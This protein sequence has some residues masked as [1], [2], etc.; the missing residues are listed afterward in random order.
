SNMPDGTIVEV[1]VS[2]S[3]LGIR[4]IG[5]GAL[6]EP[7]AALCR[8]QATVASLAVDAAAL[9]SRELMLQA[10]LVDPMVN[11]MDQAK[12]LVDK[13]LELQAAYLPQFHR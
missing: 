9:G 6:P 10:L 3:R 5:V 8:T 13:M 7:I 12:V 2:V 11:D 4:G 1:P